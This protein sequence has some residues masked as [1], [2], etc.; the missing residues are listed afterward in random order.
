MSNFFRCGLTPRVKICGW[1]VMKLS[2]KAK[3]R[4]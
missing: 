2:L 3:P 1:M 4:G